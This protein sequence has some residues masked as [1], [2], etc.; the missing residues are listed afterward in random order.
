MKKILLTS[1]GFDNEH[2]CG[3]FIQLIPSPIEFLTTCIITTASSNWKERNKNAIFTKFFLEKLGFK[4]VQFVDVE[5]E[6]A[7]LLRNFDVIYL[8]GGNPFYLFHFLKKSGADEV[9]KQMS[10]EGKIIVGTSA[11]ALVLGPSIKIIDLLHNDWNNVNLTNLGGLKLVDFSICAHY[12][13]YQ[14]KEFHIDN[15]EQE[16]DYTIQRLNDGE[17]ILVLGDKFVRI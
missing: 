2:I 3:A 7:N 5:F 17:G 1:S 12:Q 10:E 16:C 13:L 14:D 8:S 4:E 11:G 15:L 6:D 9:I